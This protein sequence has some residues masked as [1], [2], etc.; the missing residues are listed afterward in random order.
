MG[1]RS[2]GSSQAAPAQSQQAPA[3]SQGTGQSSNTANNIAAFAASQ[4]APSQLNSAQN[5]GTQN[6]GAQNYGNFSLA[7]APKFTPQQAQTAGT[8]ATNVI[9]GV[10]INPNQ[11]GSA[12][13]DQQA[14]ID[15]L[16]AQLTK[17]QE[18]NSRANVI[19]GSGTNHGSAH[20]SAMYGRQNRNSADPKQTQIANIQA[21]LQAAQQQQAALKS[22]QTIGGLQYNNMPTNMIGGKT[23]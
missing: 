4:L 22:Q 13:S 5:Y 23:Y 9:G 7:N 21:Q 14:N 10:T 3:S 15:A 18:T 19:Y 17:L 1:G 12:L 8:A 20:G 2:S 11:S 6:A 16:T